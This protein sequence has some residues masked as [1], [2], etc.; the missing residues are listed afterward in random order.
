MQ[1][2]DK[3]NEQNAEPTNEQQQISQLQ[4]ALNQLQTAFKAK[5]QQMLEVKAA[6]FDEAQQLRSINNNQSQLLSIVAQKLGL[7]TPDPQALVTAVSDLIQAQE[8]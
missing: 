4:Q 8:Q 5:E 6:A 3:T 7:S 1:N 2:Q